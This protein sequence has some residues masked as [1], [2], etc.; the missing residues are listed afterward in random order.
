MNVNYLKSGVSL[1]ENESNKPIIDT[2]L[3]NNIQKK[4]IEYLKLSNSFKESYESYSKLKLKITNK[5][6]LPDG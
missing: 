1:T 4:R 2:I 5:T 6:C 3:R